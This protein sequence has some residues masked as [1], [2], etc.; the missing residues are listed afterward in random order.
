VWYQVVGRR[1]RPE[2]R[3]F[4]VGLKKDIAN[5]PTAVT[6]RAD[7][8][9]PIS[10]KFPKHRWL[11]DELLR[12]LSLARRECYDAESAECTSGTDF[13]VQLSLLVRKLS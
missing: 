2:N 8:S 1:N 3:T 11:L 10:A 13:S 9:K 12:S 6:C 4:M 7:T 5:N